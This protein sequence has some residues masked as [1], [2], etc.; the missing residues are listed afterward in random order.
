[1]AR[2]CRDNFTFDRHSQKGEIADYIED[3][4]P[5]KFIVESEW[6]FV[7]HTVRREHDSVVKRA[8]EREICLSQH[9]DLVCKPEGSSRRY[10]L[11]E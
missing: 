3:L 5:D 9:F 6:C 7:E 4:V 8:A 11:T 2:L 1:M 10:F